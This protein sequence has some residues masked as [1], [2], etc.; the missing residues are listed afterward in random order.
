MPLSVPNS[1][2]SSMSLYL[3]LRALTKLPRALKARLAAVSRASPRFNRMRVARRAGA[4]GLEA[5]V[6]LALQLVRWRSRVLPRLKI[7]C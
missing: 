2:L 1:V 3:T 4:K 6:L 5:N 7:S